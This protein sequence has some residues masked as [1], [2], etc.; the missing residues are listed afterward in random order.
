MNVYNKKKENKKVAMDMEQN[1]KLAVRATQIERQ[2][3]KRVK[4]GKFFFRGKRKPGDI[5]R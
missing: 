3:E 1:T 2:A 5:H 4:K